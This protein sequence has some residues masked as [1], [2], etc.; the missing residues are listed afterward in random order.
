MAPTDEGEA[1]AAAL[2]LLFPPGGH[3]AGDQNRGVL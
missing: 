3:V 1:V 2:V